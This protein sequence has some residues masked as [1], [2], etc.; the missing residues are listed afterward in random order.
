MV[1]P[2]IKDSTKSKGTK[3]F[4]LKFLFFKGIKKWKYLNLRKFIKIL[5][6]PEVNAS[7]PL[8]MTSLKFDCFKKVSIK[9]VTLSGVEAFVMCR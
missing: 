1:L 7:T 3:V 4:S 6:F 2:Q 9:F 8:S 5:A